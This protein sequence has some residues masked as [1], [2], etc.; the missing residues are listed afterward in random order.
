MSIENPYEPP[1]TDIPAQDAAH[2][3]L[4]PVTFERALWT[5]GMIGGGTFGAFTLIGLHLHDVSDPR[6]TVLAS[7]AIVFAA[8][9]GI[10]LAY[11]DRQ[12]LRR[13]DELNDNGVP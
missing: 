7:F 6:L 8:I 12:F 3:A 13:N 4:L 9:C 1:Q 2:R 10:A 5:I 11:R